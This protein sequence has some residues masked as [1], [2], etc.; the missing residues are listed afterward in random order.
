MKFKVIKKYHPN[1]DDTFY[2]HLQEIPQVWYFCR[3]YID[4]YV[5]I[6]QL[7]AANCVYVFEIYHSY[8]ANMEL[9]CT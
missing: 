9:V 8:E 7:H 1:C 3:T 4:V 6:W 2:S 5:L